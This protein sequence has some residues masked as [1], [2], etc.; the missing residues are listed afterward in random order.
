MSVDIRTITDEELPSSCEAV[1]R[2]FGSDV[3]EGEHDRVRR[4]VGLDRVHAAFDG[5]RIVATMG[6]Y[7]MQLG[8]PGGVDVPAAG[9]TRVTVATSHRRQGILRRMID[10][11]FAD[12]IA[13]DEALSILWASEVV[14]YGRFGYG[15]ATE[16]ATL[17]WDSRLAGIGKP[18]HADTLELIDL[19]EAEQLLPEIRERCRH[20]QPGGFQRS[21][22]WW[23]LRRFPDH[24]WMRDGN[25]S[26]R[27]V[28]AR[29]NGQ[30]VGYATYRQ[31]ANWTDQDVPEGKISVIEVVGIDA[32]AEH[33]LWWFLSS[34][35]LFP[36]VW[37][38]MASTDSLVP[39]LAS[40]IR[41]VTRRITDGIHLRVLDVA[42]ALSMRHYH[43]P[44]QLTFA[45]T[46]PQV[47]ANTGTYRLVVDGAQGRCERT[48]DAPMATLSTKAL[49]ALYLGSG[50]VRPLA[51][52]G[53]IEADPAVL[54]DI[55]RLFGWPVTAFC[56]ED[57]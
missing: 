25:S 27:Q 10:T 8:V 35:D 11:H 3:E 54:A 28:V 43:R 30:P 9:L 49:G 57:F 14:I 26:R 44:G 48:D 51:H 40:D 19:A 15:Q 24:E 38:G 45:V 47:P 34:I 7:T 39:W 6:A 42:T 56:D 22:V 16:N 12:A 1:T 23:E 29:R 5:D 52:L 37:Q 50:K 53:H 2:G 4:V 31:K 41:A 55:E 13:N 21:P 20:N 18:D 46:D 32:T 33:S 17:S 36:K